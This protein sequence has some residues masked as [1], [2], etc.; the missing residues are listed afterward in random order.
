MVELSP[1]LQNII[2][3]IQQL[4]TTEQKE[5]LSA[6]SKPIQSK[7]TQLK[8]NNNFWNSKT[9]EQLVSEQQIQVASSISEIGGDFWP[10][11]ESVDEFN[12]FILTQRHDDR[13][14]E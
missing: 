3:E 1:Q 9:I 13:S 7:S 10:Q 14:S 6:I 11:E 2:N 8:I 4:S 12:D 5:L